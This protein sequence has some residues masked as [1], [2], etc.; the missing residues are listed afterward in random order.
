[1]KTDLES[2]HRGP[3]EPG[4]AMRQESSLGL[5]KVIGLCA[6]RG[7]ELGSIVCRLCRRLEQKKGRRS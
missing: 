2:A 6:V 5:G 4:P 7:K 3:A 1:M